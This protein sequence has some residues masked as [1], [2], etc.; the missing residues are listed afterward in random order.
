MEELVSTVLVGGALLIG[1]SLLISLAFTGAPSLPSNARAARDVIA[2]L[3]EAHIAEDAVIYE[4]GSGWGSL[5]IALARAFPQA[6]IHGV[7]LSPFPYWVSRFRA[8]RLP[9]LRFAWGDFTRR[10]LSDADVVTCY[11]MPGKMSGLADLLDA[12]VKPG[13][14]VASIEFWFRGRQ[15][16]ASRGGAQ[17]QAVALYVWPARV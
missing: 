2:L 11:L 14:C 16:A 12:Q 7:E 17:R 8:R 4:L 6:R 9:N 3:R 5:A 15:A 13:T 10:D 1:A